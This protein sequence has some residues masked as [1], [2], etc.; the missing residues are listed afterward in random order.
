M[1]IDTRDKLIASLAAASRKDFYKPS[2]TTEGAGTWHSLWMLAGYPPAASTPPAYNIGSG[3]VPTS[4][5]TGALPFTNPSAGTLTYLDQMMM[6]GS[7]IGKLIIYDRLWQCSGLTTNNANPTTLSITTPG[8][9]TRPDALGA[10]VEIWGEVYS[11]P[12][13]TGSAWS[14]VYVD[15]ADADQTATYTHPANAET[16]GQM[17]PFLLF[18]TTTGV[19]QVKSF[20]HTVATG[21]AGSIGITLLRRIAEIPLMIANVGDIFDAFFLGMPRIYDDTCLAAMIM[22]S[23]TTSGIVQGSV[24]LGQG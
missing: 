21:T 12:G 19:K 22:C 9:L 6:A 17:F 2:A 3:Y 16:A 24:L 11:A 15:Q 10:G 4:V 14:V 8:S 13:A 20:T 18:G 23:T 7:V 1:A 5:T